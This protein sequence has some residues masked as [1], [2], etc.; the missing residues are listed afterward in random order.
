MK[1]LENV[2]MLGIEPIEHK[3]MQIVPM[4]F[5]KTLLPDPAS[6]GPR[7]K[8][9]T[10]IGIVAE[11]IKDGV[12]KKIYIYQVKDHEECFKETNSQGVSY[13]TGVPAMIGAK[14]ML[15][16]IWSGAGVFNMEQMDPDPFMEEMNTQGL[17]WQIKEL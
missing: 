17:P 2:G 14:L 7:T 12:K 6:L 1:C 16:G 13:T 15:K 8:G 11:G 3:G 10:N 5:L 9:K 4:E